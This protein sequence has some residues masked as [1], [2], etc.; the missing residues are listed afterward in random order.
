MKVARADGKA[1]QLH[2]TQEPP[3]NS[4][5]PAVDVLFRSVA[6]TYGPNVLAVVLTGMGSDGVRGSEEIKAAGGQVLV[7]DEESSVV[8]GMPGQVAAAGLADGIYPL[9]Q[10]PGEITRRVQ[11]TRPGLDLSDHGQ[12]ARPAVKVHG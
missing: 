12:S 2:M 6:R 5:R 8:W 9:N 7:Q 10:I 3:E 11:A 1:V 4:C